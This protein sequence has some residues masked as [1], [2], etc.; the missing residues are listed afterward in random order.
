MPAAN[1]V[2]ARPPR[3]TPTALRRDKSG[4]KRCFAGDQR[5]SAYIIVRRKLAAI[6]RIRSSCGIYA[7]F[8]MWNR[9]LA[10]QT[11]LRGVRQPPL[12]SLSEMRR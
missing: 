5:A 6:D 3:P 12:D 10:G 7:L 8:E 9:K 11:V 2:T 1:R 4:E